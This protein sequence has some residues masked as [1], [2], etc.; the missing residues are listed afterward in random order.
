MEFTMQPKARKAALLTLLSICAATA[1]AQNLFFGS[2]S[3]GGSPN[4]LYTT[5][6]DGNG[7][8]NILP[9]SVVVAGVAVDA[10]ADMVFW[11]QPHHGSGQ[12]QW[13]IHAANRNGG[14]HSTIATWTQ[15]IANSYG[16]AVDRTNQRVYWT[17][18]N[19][20]QSSNYDGTGAAGV[21]TSANPT[22]LEVDPAANK[23]F[24]TNTSGAAVNI[25]SA[26]LNGSNP[27]ALA[28]LPA[29]THVFGLTVNPGTQTVYWSDYTGGTISALPYTGGTPSTIL[30]GT[31][32]LVGL[33][34]EPLTNRLYMV[35]KGSASVAWM[36]PTG[37]P[38]TTVFTGV[39]QTR[40]E[41]HDIAAVVPTPASLTILSIAGIAALRRRRTA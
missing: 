18:I 1:H 2:A 7:L 31:P 36:L 32:F 19:G 15:P 22:D 33:D 34:Y 12:Q 16:L 14:S 21:L 40:G 8:A 38:L 29:N 9:V 37:G 25:W 39:G 17:D 3:V 20:I 30:S 11:Q 27:V 26:D 13:T 28:T 41:M 24:W 35:Q 10:G 4:A 6:L 5:D 23:L